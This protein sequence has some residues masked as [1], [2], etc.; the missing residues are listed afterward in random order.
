MNFFFKKPPPK[1][2]ESGVPFF[3]MSGAEFDEVYVGVGS[4]RVRELFEAAKKRSPSL[5]FIDEIDAIGGKRS[6]RD[7]GTHRMTLNQLLSEMDGFLSDDKVIVIGAT[8][9]PKTLD[10]ALTRPGRLDRIITVDPPDCRGRAAILNLYLSKVQHAP[11]IDPETLAKGLPGYCGAELQNI[12][13]IAAIK[14]A[15]DDK[16]QVDNED[17]EYAK[18]RVSMGTENRSKIIPEHER[19]VTAWHEAGHA[20]TAMLSEGADPVHKA[21]IIPRGSGILGL[22]L[23]HPDEDRYSMSRQM[24]LSRL[25]VALAGRAAEEV[26]LGH[27]DVTAGAA[28][29]FESATALA[30]VMVRK[31]GMAEDSIGVVD[32]STSEEN[33]GA[34]LSEETKISIE[35]ATRSLLDE[36][37]TD[38]TALLKDNHLKL[39]AIAEALLAHETLDNMQLRSIINGEEIAPPKKKVSVTTS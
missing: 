20:L 27:A 32:Y 33:I 21:T 24:M 26:L 38:A 35:A 5:I 7:Q 25:R 17:V 15:M 12:V 10:T 3:Y 16:E 9:T 4:K 14:A 31:Y 30:R 37:L 18:D 13:N 23:Q 39:K 28:S 11:D 22:V 36:A 19:T 2:K 6:P 1:K 29:D 8:N 34:Y